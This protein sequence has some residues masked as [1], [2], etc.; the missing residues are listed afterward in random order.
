M[1]VNGKIKMKLDLSALDKLARKSPKAFTKAMEKGAIQLLTW[2]NN[3][4]AKESAKPPIRFGVLR[5]SSSAFV[6]NK[7]V[8]VFPQQIKSGAK[9]TITPNKSHQGPSTTITVGWNTD[10]AA[11][12][13]E[14]DGEWGPFTMQD[15]NAGAKWIEKHLKADKEDLM[16]MIR[17][18]V[19]RDLKL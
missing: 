18:E 13:H 15:G 14:W 5:G 11:K 4:S 2:M 3:G 19:K 9:E 1:V 7:L 10:Y 8:Q 16:K 12:M 6:G 17:L